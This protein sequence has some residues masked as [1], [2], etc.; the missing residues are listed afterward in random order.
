MY[1]VSQKTRNST[2]VQTYNFGNGDFHNSFT[3]GLS[4]NNYI[5]TKS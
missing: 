2:F 5:A 1:I 4:S 3:F